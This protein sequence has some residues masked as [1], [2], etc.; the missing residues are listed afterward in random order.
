MG[1]LIPLALSL[2][3][4]I[5]KWLFGA[6]GEKTAAAVAQVVQTVTGTTDDQVAQQAINANPQLAAQLRY[7][8]AQLA[9]QQEQAARQAELDLLTARLKDVADARAQTVSLAQASSPVQWAPVVVSFV[10]LTTFG[11]VM[12]AA[13]TRALPAGSETIL[14]MLLGTLAAMA[15]ATVS[16]WVGSSAGSAQKTDLLYR[17]APKAGGGA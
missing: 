12:W 13:L 14:N 11:V 9:A 6:A 16:Y 10:V 5:G 17:S 2:A 1:A 4:E 15:T 7:Q 3:P 8:L